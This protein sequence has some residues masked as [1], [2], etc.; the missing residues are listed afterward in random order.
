MLVA[1]NILS[2]RLCFVLSKLS[3]LETNRSNILLFVDNLRN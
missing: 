1:V 2:R 3:S